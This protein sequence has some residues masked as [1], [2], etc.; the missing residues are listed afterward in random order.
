MAGI[1]GFF[2][3]IVLGSYVNR[4]K[5]HYLQPDSCSS[6]GFILNIYHLSDEQP[7]SQALHAKRSYTVF[8]DTFHTHSFHIRWV[9]ESV[10][11]NAI[12]HYYKN[13]CT[14]LYLKLPRFDLQ[15]AVL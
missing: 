11:M 6:V 15:K 9:F 2:E 1:I 12:A 8:V 3:A 10:M 4:H 13:L 7:L 5:S 14:P